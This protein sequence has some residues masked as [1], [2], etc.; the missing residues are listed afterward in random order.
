MPQPIETVLGFSPTWQQAADALVKAFSEQ[1]QV[2]IEAGE[3]SESELTRAQTLE[4]E[5]YANP[6]WTYRI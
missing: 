6:A 5:K 2:E 3:P 1:L 4:R